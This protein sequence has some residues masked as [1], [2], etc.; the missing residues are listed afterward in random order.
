LKTPPPDFPKIAAA[1]LGCFDQI[2]SLLGLSGKMS[3][4]EFLPLNPRRADKKPGSFA[5]NSKTGAWGDWA[6]DVKGGDLIS[7]A[8]YIR[9]GSNSDAALW[10]AEVLNLPDGVAPTQSAPRAQA[11]ADGAEWVAPIPYDAPKPPAGNMRHGKPS[12]VWTYRDADGRVMFHHCRFDPRDQR[13]QFSPL[14]LW[15]DASGRLAWAWKWPPAGAP[16]PLYGLPRLAEV[17]GAPVIITEGEKAADAAALLFPDHAV[18]T[19]AGGANAVGKA[20]ITPLAGRECWLWPDN[21]APG[22]QAMDKLGARLSE[23]GAVV[24]RFDLAALAKR[25]ATDA[26]GAAILEPGP[27]LDA[28]D[29]AA[30]LA[31]R[32]WLA[33]HI[34]LLIESGELLEITSAP[35]APEAVSKPEPSSKPRTDTGEPERASKFEMRPKGLFRNSEK[36]P[37]FVCPPF[38]VTAKG[39]DPEAAGWGLL[40]SLHDP[41]GRP[42]Y[43][44][45]PYRTLRGDGAAALELLMDRGFVP[46]KGCDSFLVE[47]LREVETDKRAKW[48]SRN[49]WQGRDPATAVYV[50]AAHTYGAQRG[51]LWLLQSDGPRLDPFKTRGTPEEWA[52]N[53]GALCVGNSRL[54]FAASAAFAAPLLFPLGME[55]GGF[56]YVGKSSGGKTTALKVGASVCG[57]PDYADRL[58]AT[59]NGLE[60]IFLAKSDAPAY[61]DELGQLGPQIAGE[62]VYMAANGSQKARANRNGGARACEA[63]RTV[64]LL[65]SE[66]SLAAHMGE[67]GRSPKA[68]Q[69]ARLADIPSDAGRGLGIF[70]DLHDYA[71]GHEFAQALTRAAANYYGTPFA[72]FLSRLMRE[73]GESLWLKLREDIRRFEREYLKDDQAG[74]QAHRVATR[75]GLVAAA[76]ELAILWLDLPWKKGAASEAAGKLFAAWIDARGGAGD[77][78][79]RAMLAQVRDFLSRHGEARFTDWD[80]PAADT[81][82]HAPRVINRAG[83]R[84]ITDETMGKIPD[85]RETDFFVFPEVWRN[86]VCKG[87]DPSA[88]AH[89]L[90]KRGALKASDDGR[91]ARS[92]TL[93]GEGK[94]RVYHLTPS[95]W[96]GER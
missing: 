63:W 59:D 8:A 50:T 66:V 56:S 83:F 70:E 89:L 21:D 47:F 85:E 34:R 87:H 60:S 16:V 96:S 46:R 68:G 36:G 77:Q 37:F 24:K 41:D 48:V 20:D 49:G 95:I 22:R 74:G 43:V 94:R 55:S 4:P 13:K 93:P 76:G 73:R 71:S 10:L 18:C 45:V 2:M 27:A 86:E 32:G 38:E 67:A 90:A 64:F 35:F 14:T 53:V 15:R 72:A 84:R 91:L 92:L 75:F 61:L 31:A 88:V 25:P 28:G 23:S 19:F 42:H 9:G 51:E 40:L 1:A 54:I 7:L 26:S 57:A 82:K 52:Q 11:P 30:D 17:P 6:A 62:A 12:Q 81:D 3:G 80:R 65:S 5:I 58:R 44:T 78:E 29:D 69:Q 79:E 33:A 39:S